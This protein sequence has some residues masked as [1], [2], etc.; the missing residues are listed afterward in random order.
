MLDLCI[1]AQLLFLFL[2]VP[3]HLPD[4]VRVNLAT[5]DHS[6]LERSYEDDGWV[7]EGIK[8]PN[9]CV[10]GCT[11]PEQTS[12]WGRFSCTKENCSYS[13]CEGCVV[14]QLLTVSIAPSSNISCTHALLYRLNNTWGCDGN[15]CYGELLLLPCTIYLGAK[16]MRWRHKFICV[17]ECRS[18]VLC[19]YMLVS[20]CALRARYHYVCPNAYCDCF[21]VLTS[22][23]D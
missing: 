11:G 14:S 5:H 4:Y 23:T 10:N 12:G 21:S 19:N 7:C 22:H 15:D 6:V 3:K 9:G 8:F 17:N 18:T 13:L 2:Q 1:V 16:I 20:H